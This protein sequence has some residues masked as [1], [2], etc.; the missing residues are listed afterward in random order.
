ME[1]SVKVTTPLTATTGFVPL[2]VPPPGLTPMVIVTGPLKLIPIFP[3]ASCALT[4]MAGLMETFMT[5]SLGW[6]VK[7]SLVAI[8]ASGVQVGAGIVHHGLNT[9]LLLT[10]F[11][12]PP[13]LD[14]C[15]GPVL[16]PQ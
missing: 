14:E 4:T 10:T 15:M 2:S 7:T 1:R 16:L 9:T 13:G 12:V 8:P 11:P 5:S 3:A 6:A